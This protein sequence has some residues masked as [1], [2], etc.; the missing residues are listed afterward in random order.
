MR[1]TPHKDGSYSIPK[2]NLYDDKISRKEIYVKGC[3]NPFRISIDKKTNALYWGEVGPD[4]DKDTARGPKGYDEINR[5][6]KAGFYG[7]PFFVADNKAYQLWDYKTNKAIKT[8]ELKAHNPS[9]FNAGLKIL[10]E[11][12]KPLIFYAYDKHPIFGAGARNAM[13]GPVIYRDASKGRLPNYLNRSLVIYD[14]MRGFLKFVKM[15]KEGKIISYH[16]SSQSFVHPIAVKQGDDGSLY[17][18]EYGKKWTQNKDGRVL[19]LSFNKHA[20]TKEAS[21]KDPILSMMYTSQCMACHQLKERSVGPSFK[22]VAQKYNH[23]EDQSKKQIKDKLRNKIKNGGGGVWGPTPMPPQ[24]HV[25][26]GDLDLIID[27]ILNL[28]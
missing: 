20:S 16:K 4:A 25:S 12:Q 19:K 21:T 27:Y 6:T 24:P 17:V 13:T 5:A 7:W 18:L 10:P 23:L 2:G 28:K 9:K 14:W 1:I 11:A 3:R 15:N 26:N 22:E 8:F